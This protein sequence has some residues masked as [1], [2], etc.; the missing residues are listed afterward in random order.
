MNCPK[1]G[2][3][4]IKDAKFCAKCGVSLTGE[5][6][7]KN[8]LIDK[9]KD[10]ANKTKN[11]CFENLKLVFNFL[12]NP[13]VTLKK[14]SVRFNE[15]KNSGILALIISVIAT[16]VTLVTAM[17]N[18]VVV[19]RFDWQEGYVTVLEWS[20]LKNIDYIGRIFENLLLLLVII[21]VISGVYYIAS[22]IIKKEVK[23]PRLVGAI[24]LSI[25]PLLIGALVISPIVSLISVKLGILVYIISGIYTL[26]LL[27]ETINDELELQGNMKYYFNVICYTILIIIS[28]IAVTELF[29]TVLK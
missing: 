21:A 14:E 4:N 16:L 2:A 26:I 20:N 10:G 7:E 27:Y 13:S 1:C 24:T 12:K 6:K 28:Y 5:M 3:E 29:L 17:V 23:F 25:I 8:E 11:V 15:F 19:K 9:L 22:L 18:A